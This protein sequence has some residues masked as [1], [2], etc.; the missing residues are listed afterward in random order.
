MLTLLHSVNKMLTLIISCHEPLILLLSACKVLIT[1][2]SGHEV[3]KTNKSGNHKL[4]QPQ[5]IF[6]VYQ[7]SLCLRSHPPPALFM[8]TSREN[9]QK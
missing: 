8:H 2:P 4:C 3:T 1:L 7:N 6:V 9:N 5:V